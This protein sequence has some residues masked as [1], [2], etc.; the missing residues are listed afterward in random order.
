MRE[1]VNTLRREGEARTDL[2][3]IL[4]VLSKHGRECQ[5]GV[6]GKK[7]KGA[8]LVIVLLEVLPNVEV[9]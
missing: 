2:V 9:N 8:H 4:L 7:E 6:E 5:T 1:K 3:I